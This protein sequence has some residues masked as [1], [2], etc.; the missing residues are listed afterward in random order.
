M[1]KVYLLLLQLLLEMMYTRADQGW[2][3]LLIVKPKL[4]RA[5]T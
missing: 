2:L 3:N 5:A 4:R 1:K